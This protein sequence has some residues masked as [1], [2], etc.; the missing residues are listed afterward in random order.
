MRIIS[1]IMITTGTTMATM[2]G[3]INGVDSGGKTGNHICRLVHAYIQ[4]VDMYVYMYFV[5][6]VQYIHS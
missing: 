5:Y 6:N 2:L 4:C 3:S 1:S